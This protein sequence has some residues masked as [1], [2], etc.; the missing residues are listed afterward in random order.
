MYDVEALPFV[1]SDDRQR[2]GTPP[3]VKATRV[4]T[5]RGASPEWGVSRFS[6]YR[7]APKVFFNGSNGGISIVDDRATAIVPCHRTL[8][9]CAALWR[10]GR[11]PD[12]MQPMWGYHHCTGGWWRGVAALP[13][14]AA[15]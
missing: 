15:P 13:P 11:Q 14:G 8:A 2:D 4:F 1:E 3:G 9:G 12:W 7:F 10:S 6:H 5:Q